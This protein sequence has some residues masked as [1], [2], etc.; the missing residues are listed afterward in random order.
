MQ[1]RR[2]KENGPLDQRLT[3]KALRLRKEAQG[4]PPGVM[5]DQLNGQARQ[6][7]TALHMLEWLSVPGLQPPR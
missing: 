1:P 2:F 6:A 4:T 5:R 7:E 3:E